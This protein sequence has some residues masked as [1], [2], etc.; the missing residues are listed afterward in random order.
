[1]EGVESA[2]REQIERVLAKYDKFI[3][4]KAHA[5]AKTYQSL[6]F[7]D[8]LQDVRLAF[9]SGKL[10]LPNRKKEALS[11]S[12]IDMGFRSFIS[13]KIRR[14]Q[15]IWELNNIASLDE[16]E[17]LDS[18]ET[19]SPSKLIEQQDYEKHV[20]KMIHNIIEQLK[21]THQY[22]YAMHVK[23]YTPTQIANE[24]GI[25]KEAVYYIVNKTNKRI[26]KCLTKLS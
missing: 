18:V 26:K 17:R 6:N 21:P 22:V 1:M 15:S 20:K 14:A 19:K 4:K 8:L 7:E 2:D 24:V 25:T 13:N 23:K 9:L 11:A 3:K 10:K 5:Y 16:L 12:F